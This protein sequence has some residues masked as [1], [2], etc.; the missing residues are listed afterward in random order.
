MKEYTLSIYTEDTV[1]LL[2]RIAAMFTRRKINIESLN[3]SPTEVE[4]IHRFT[5]LINSSEE[6]VKKLAFQLEKQVDVLKA[7]YNTNEEIIWQEMA[8]YKVPTQV[9]AEK[10][11]V[12]RLLRAHGARVVVIRHDYI[13]FEKTGQREET[14]KL[15]EILEP[16]GLIEFVRSG[17]IAI[18]KASNGFHEKLLDFEQTASPNGH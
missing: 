6:Q 14:T 13:I 18:I 8:L 11:Q 16:F 15:T 4:G 9:I 17:R 5:I 10:V 7:Y 1:G 12:E 2:N 3:T